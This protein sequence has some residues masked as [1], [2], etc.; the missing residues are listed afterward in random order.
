MLYHII[1]QGVCEL[2]NKKPVLSFA[3]QKG[4][5][6][7]TT[8][9]KIFSEYLALVKKINTLGID[10]DSQTSFTARFF[11]INKNPITDYKEP[12]IH[13]YYD[14]DDPANEDWDGRS[15]IADIFFGKIPKPYPT[16][17]KRFD[18]IPSDEGGLFKA[19]NVKR[20]EMAEKIYGQL[21]N[22]IS[23]PDVQK[24]YDMFVIDTPPAK[25]PL[26]I[27]A[28]KA[29]THLVIPLEIELQAIEGL[30]GLL[31]LW[32]QEAMSRP[33]NFPLT[34][35]GI[36]PN[37]VHSRRSSDKDLLDDLRSNSSYCD[38]I[39]P[40]QMVDRRE[41]PLCDLEQKSIFQFPNRNLAKQE[42]LAICD[43]I[44]RKIV[45]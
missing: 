16:H 37:K 35:V 10:I 19:E 9:S 18:I 2:M 36:L 22:F 42:A 30:A 17:I 20:Q 8:W 12:P 38:Y 4:G 39:M 6:G 43:Y 14:P 27:S 33:A 5:V 25:G 28:F 29:M 3:N 11:G 45:T 44:Y 32:K 41:I 23:L 34:L 26:T 7:K 21:N 15:S 31:Q 13:P 24:N 40:V 1:C